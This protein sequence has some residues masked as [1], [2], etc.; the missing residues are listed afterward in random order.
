[1]PAHPIGHD[2]CTGTL[3]HAHDQGII[4]IED[5]CPFRWQALHKLAFLESRSLASPECGSAAEGSDKDPRPLAPTSQTQN[6][7]S[8]PTCSSTWPSLPGIQV[9]PCWQGPALSRI[10]AARFR[11]V[12]LPQLPVMATKVT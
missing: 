2:A 9:A 4:G 1:M 6:R 11:V 5:G 7:V 8:G 3:R 10:A 12:V